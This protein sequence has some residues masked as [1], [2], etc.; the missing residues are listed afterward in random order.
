MEI[1]EQEGL[2]NVLEDGVE[3]YSAKS[4][5][6]AQGYI[7]WRNRADAGNTAEDCQCNN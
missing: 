1:I 3:V 5:E 6:E 2:F 7:D 4:Q